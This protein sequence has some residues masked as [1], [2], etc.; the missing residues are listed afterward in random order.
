MACLPA[1]VYN[2]RILCP[3]VLANTG[4]RT[5]IPI[6]SIG[7]NIILSVVSFFHDM[8]HRDG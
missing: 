6:I 4:P 3:G 5:A 8:Y 2:Y 7:H 1:T